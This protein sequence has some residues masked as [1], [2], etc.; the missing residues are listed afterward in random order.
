MGALDKALPPPPRP[1]R[2]SECGLFEADDTLSPLAAEIESLRH[3][4]GQLKSENGQLKSENGQLKSENRQLT[5]NNDL[6]SK[7]LRREQHA[8]AEGYERLRKQVERHSTVID[9]Q[10][11][12]LKGILSFVYVTASDC[13]A[14]LGER[15][16]ED[17][18]SHTPPN[19]AIRVYREPSDQAPKGSL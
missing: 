2:A 6:L 16:D 11:D 19:A 8:N 15:H 1:R 12:A 5:V 9:V 18:S 4:N 10:N 17:G 7:T 13:M 14:K 3:E